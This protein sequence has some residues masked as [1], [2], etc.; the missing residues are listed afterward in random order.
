MGRESERAGERKGWGERG[1]ER[2]RERDGVRVSALVLY[3]TI[4]SPRSGTQSTQCYISPSCPSEK[5]S[6]VMMFCTTTCPH[7][8]VLIGRAHGETPVTFR[9]LVCRLML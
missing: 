5:D 6:I 9:K 8:F 3:D 2:E 1:E 4:N 7:H